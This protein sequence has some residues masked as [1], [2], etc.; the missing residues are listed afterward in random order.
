MSRLEHV[1][2]ARW[3]RQTA[4]QI[5]VLMVRGQSKGIGEV[6]EVLQRGTVEKPKDYAAGVQEVIDLIKEKMQ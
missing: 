1:E 5:G 6:I 3:A 4:E 2:G